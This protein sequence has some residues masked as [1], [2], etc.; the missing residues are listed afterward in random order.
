MARAKRERGP[1][2]IVRFIPGRKP[3]Q[4]H[5]KTDDRLMLTGGRYSRAAMN[6]PKGFVAGVAVGPG[7]HRGKDEAGIGFQLSEGGII[8]PALPNEKLEPVPVRD[9]EYRDEDGTRRA[10]QYID[11]ATFKAVGTGIFNVVPYEE[12]NVVYFEV[13]TGDVLEEESTFQLVQADVFRHGSVEFTGGTIVIDAPSKKRAKKDGGGVSV[14]IRESSAELV[15]ERVGPTVGGIELWR[16]RLWRVRYS[17]KDSE[18]VLVRQ[19]N[20]FFLLLVENGEPTYKEVPASTFEKR[21]EVLVAAVERKA[22]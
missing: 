21:Y 16:A 11:Y 17:D 13:W 10:K 2:N 6:T 15:A 9:F 8:V 22:A 5:G 7:V 12:E 1:H 14:N 3:R 4:V 18:A 19:L 20:R